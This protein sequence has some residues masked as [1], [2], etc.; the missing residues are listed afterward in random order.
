[1]I[2]PRS[3]SWEVAEQGFRIRDSTS[4]SRALSAVTGGELKCAPGLEKLRR[5]PRRTSLWA[6]RPELADSAVPLQRTFLPASSAGRTES[7]LPRA[8]LVVLRH[9][10]LL[11]PAALKLADICGSVLPRWAPVPA[12]QAPSTWN[13]GF[14]VFPA[15]KAAVTT[16][17]CSQG[18][19]RLLTSSEMSPRF[20]FFDSSSIFSVPV[21]DAS[22]R[23]GKSHRHF[24]HF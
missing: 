19:F 5:H 15:Q 21:P 10:T 11:Q 8:A 24:R 6:G 18:G 12:P 20:S 3:H 14:L 16:S 7:G 2:C 23:P 13:N 4:K 22:L 1:M 9:T 17:A